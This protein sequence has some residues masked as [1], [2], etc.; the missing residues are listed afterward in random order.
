VGR[1]FGFPAHPS[2]QNPASEVGRQCDLIE[3]AE[4]PCF[5]LEHRTAVRV[6]S[7]A[8]L[9]SLPPRTDSRGRNPVAQGAGG[10]FLWGARAPDL[11][12][13][14]LREPNHHERKSD[15]KEKARG[16]TAP[17]SVSQFL[18][19]SHTFVRWPDW[20]LGPAVHQAKR[21]EYVHAG[22]GRE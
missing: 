15:Q 13:D 20:W 17:F 21:W 3:I 12:Q 4:L 9:A 1:E 22:T 6:A 18:P 2:S 19:V 10:V 11:K 8:P 14:L 5:P 16:C 7:T